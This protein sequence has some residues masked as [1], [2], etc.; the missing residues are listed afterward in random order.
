MTKDANA[1]VAKVRSMYGKMLTTVQ[2]DELLRKQSVQEISAYLKDKTVYRSA[3]AGVQDTEVHRGQLELLLHKDVLYQYV[4][5]VKYVHAENNV[6][7]YIIMDMEIE[8]ILSRIRDIIS[9]REVDDYIASVP[10]FVQPY[11]SFNI[12]DMV[13]VN[14]ME[15]LIEF[16]KNTPYAS[17]LKTCKKHLEA[18]GQNSQSINYTAYETVLRT[19]YFEELLKKAEKNKSASARKQLRELITMRAETMNLNT[20]QRM[21]TYF[22]E[23]TSKIRSVLLPFR[24]KLTQRQ[25][26]ALIEARDEQTFRRELSTT[27][28]GKRISEDAAFIENETDNM[29]YRLNMH[30]LRFSTDPQVVFMAFM[31]LREMETENIV[32]IIEGVR[33]QR[34]PEKIQQLLYRA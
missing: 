23:D 25:L 6:Y 9:S 15:Q 8:T 5:L 33:Y 34:A 12:F 30:M 3:L 27:Y 22:H 31:L 28:Y 26:D 32:R 18:V 14:N 7:A 4:R 20:I 21:K 11:V 17:V 29:R 10:S 13:N 2:Y 16:L 1:V 19:Y 24:C